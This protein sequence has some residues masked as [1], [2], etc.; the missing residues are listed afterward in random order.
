V[1]LPDKPAIRAAY[2]TA[3]VAFLNACP[4]AEEHEAE[5]FV[6]AMATLIFTTM[7]TYVEEETNDSTDSH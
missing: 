4:M 5:D 6:D 7:Q 2:E 3:V 1:N